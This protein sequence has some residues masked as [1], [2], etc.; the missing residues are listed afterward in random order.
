M[1]LVES[2][3]SV[4]ILFTYEL[5][6]RRLFLFPSRRLWT[7]PT[8]FHLRRNNKWVIQSLPL[9]S[10]GNRGNACFTCWVTSLI[11]DS[12]RSLSRV[13]RADH[14]VFLIS[15]LTRASLSLITFSTIHWNVTRLCLPCSMEPSMSVSA[16]RAAFFDFDFGSRNDSGRVKGISDEG[17]GGV[18]RAATYTW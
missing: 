16:C 1:L 15:S 17:E 18:L 11:I 8:L 9:R 2:D 7:A 12:F 5:I 6:L 4:K 10:C 3:N 14:D 13:L